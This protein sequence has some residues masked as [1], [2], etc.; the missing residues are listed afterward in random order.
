MIGFETVGNA[1]LIAHDD[2][3]VLV[4]DPWFTGEPYFGSWTMK[5]DIPAAPVEHIRQCR[6]VWLSHGHPDHA[7]AASLELLSGKTFL[8]PDH[9]G[10]RMRRELTELGFQVTTLAD[11]QW[12]PLSPRIRVM[13]VADYNQDGILLVD[14]AGHLLVDLND[15]VERGW[16][17]FV[18]GIVKQ[19][20]SSFLLKLFGYGDADMINI[21]GR[22]GRR[23]LPPPP[24]ASAEDRATWD[25]LFLDKLDFWTRYFGTRFVIPFS[26]FHA[27]QRRDSVWAQPYTTPLT[28]YDGFKSRGCELL[29]AFVRFDCER[30]ELT[31]LDPPEHTVVVREPEDF[32][33]NWSEPLEQA[34]VAEVERYFRGI[35]FLRDRLDTVTLRVGG[36]DHAVELNPRPVAG[37]GVAFEVPRGSLMSSVRYQVFDDLLIGNFM[38]TT[39][40]G[41]WGSAGA[42]HVLYPSFTPY[43]ARYAD[44]AGLRTRAELQE[45]FRSYRQRAPLEYLLHHWETAGVQR[46]RAAINPHSR[47]FRVATRVYSYLK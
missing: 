15:A 10:H 39:L 38:K 14:V 40:E 31:R 23:L 19:Y 18:R 32:G 6:Y 12:T 29:P 13:S 22:D 7:N 34:E 1:T 26:T 45:Y 16:G 9:A 30:E 24:T 42:P 37:R 21:F 25:K 28:A 11:R 35:E 33:D 47:L 41:E 4:T 43:V 20:R 36:K 5:Y 46:L 17:R 2:V 44:N 3:P 27:Y 8:V